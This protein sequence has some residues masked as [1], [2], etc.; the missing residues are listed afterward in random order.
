[1]SS[2]GPRTVLL[3]C[4]LLPSRRGPGQDTPVDSEPSLAP[5]RDA[6]YRRDCDA[7]LRRAVVVIGGA[8]AAVAS[9]WLRDRAW[10][11]VTVDGDEF[12]PV[13]SRLAGLPFGPPGFQLGVTVASTDARRPHCL[14]PAQAAAR[15]LCFGALCPLPVA[16]TAAPPP[17]APTAALPPPAQ[18]VSH[19]HRGKKARGGRV[20]NAAAAPNKKKPKTEAPRVV[21]SSSPTPPP[22]NA[23]G[24]TSTLV[25]GA[26]WPTEAAAQRLLVAAVHAGAE[27]VAVVPATRALLA[28]FPDAAAAAARRD[29]VTATCAGDLDVCELL[30]PP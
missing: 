15:F 21:A 6:A 22:N 19:N 26:A 16:S 11:V 9:L 14:T 28:T 1:M 3:E 25:L 12:W 20:G 17:A 29:I 13:V 4:S 30:V 10:V 27:S 23:T 8:A 18:P 7:A 5:L 24:R 2:R